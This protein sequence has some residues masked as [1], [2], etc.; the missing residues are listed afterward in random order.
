MKP[1]R[2]IMK[3]KTIVIFC[4]YIP[5]F[6]GGIERY[7]DNLTR[8]FV[9]LGV[10]PVIVTSNFN[11]VADNETVNG[12]DIIRLPVF[13]LFLSR[14]PIFKINRKYHAQIEKL[15]Q[16]QI[17]AVIVNTRFHLTSHIG[18]NYGYRKHIPVYLIEH[19]SN[20]VTLN[21]R[22]I[23]FFANRYEDFLT[24][25]LKK[26]ITGFYGVSNACNEW[27]KHFNI[28]SSG[29]WYNSIDCEQSLQRRKVHSDIRLLYAGRL[30]KQKGVENILS[31]F[32]ELS[33]KYDNLTLTIAGDGPD[34]E[35]YEARFRKDNIHFAG[36]LNFQQLLDEYA[37][38]DIF[39]YPPLWPEGLPTSVLEAGLMNCC[40]IGTP[41][42]GIKE[43]IQN[44]ENGLLVDTTM[45]SLRDAMEEMIQNSELREEYGAA[46][47]ER[48][49]NHFSWRIT[50]Q[51]VLDDIEAGE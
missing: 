29:T 38:T 40:V 30:I 48:I 44:G 35:D 17:D 37:Q 28:A 25:R 33:N 19:G 49:K 42:G 12:V 1:K 32:S 34:K 14:Y 10:K 3:S 5:P 51:K 43:I 31:A 4:A 36:K 7:V 46:L 23:D 47:N 6:L 13:S 45:N 26:R 41:M 22:F 18:A 27:L 16:Y 20:Y 15:D 11:Q 9:K 8:Q 2:G 24:W 21:N 39:L 50:A